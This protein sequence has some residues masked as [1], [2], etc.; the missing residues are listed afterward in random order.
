MSE[1]TQARGAGSEAAEAR[2]FRFSRGHLA[3]F[4]LSGLLLGA[5]VVLVGMAL[6]EG[7]SAVVPAVGGLGMAALAVLLL[8]H[9][10]RPAEGDAA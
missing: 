8:V 3:L 7:G 1:A 2:P 4:Y 5:D 6:A 10:R 9:A